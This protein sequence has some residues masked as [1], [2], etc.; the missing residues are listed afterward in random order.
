[1]FTFEVIHIPTVLQDTSLVQ[2]SHEELLTYQGEDAEAKE[3]QDH[4][5]NEFLHRAQQGPDDDL[6]TWGGKGPVW[7]EAPTHTHSRHRQ[8]AWSERPRPPM[9]PDLWTGWNWKLAWPRILLPWLLVL[10]LPGESCALG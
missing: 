6:Q 8:R 3:S 2:T 7:E 10:T 1:M 9:S 5:V 4:H